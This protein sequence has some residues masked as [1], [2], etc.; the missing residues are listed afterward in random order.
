[1]KYNFIKT[2]DKET[3]ENLLKEGFKLVSQDGNVVTFL[4]N[5]SLTFENTNNKIQYSNML[6]F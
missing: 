1:M 2:S 6:T 5:H 4:N 3:K